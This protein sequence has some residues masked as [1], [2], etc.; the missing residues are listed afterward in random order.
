VFVNVR[1]IDLDQDADGD[2]GITEA[3]EQFEPSPAP[4]TA[5]IDDDNGNGILDWIDAGPVTGEND[6]RPF[7]ITAI[8][9][10]ARPEI[11]AGQKLYLLMPEEA[12]GRRPIRRGR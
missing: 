12:S 3:D 11:Y 4:I 9:S 1:K 2:G 7:I 5:N 10:Q 8:L 6:L